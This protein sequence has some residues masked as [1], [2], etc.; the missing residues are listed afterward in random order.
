MM[1]DCGVPHTIHSDNALEFKSERWTKLMKMYMIKNTY[2]EAYHPNLNPCEC[3]GGVLKVATSHLLLVTGAPLSF[4][5]Y[6][7]EYIALLQSVIAHWNL[8]W[9]TPHTLHFGDTPDISVFRFVFW[10]PIHTM[11]PVTPFLVPGCSLDD[12]LESPVTLGMRFAFSLLYMT[13]TLTSVKSLHVQSFD[14]N[15]HGNRLRPWM[16]MSITV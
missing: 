9:E 14:V 16:L 2:M 4:R 3:C 1:V 12:S 11:P 5:C 6:A 7:L 10:S 13:M 15:T 8:N